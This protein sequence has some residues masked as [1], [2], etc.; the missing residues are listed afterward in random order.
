MTSDAERMALVEAYLS[1]AVEGHGRAAAWLALDQIDRGSRCEDVIVDLL[2]A[3]QHEVGERWLANEWTVADE[4][5]ASGSTQ[6]AL[7]AV[8]STVDV[9]EPAGSVLV[10]CAEGDWHSL[11][12]QM[13]AEM[14]RA[15]GYDVAFLGASTPAEHV[16]D[17]VRRR[18]PDAVAI[19]CNLPLFFPGV[20]RLA[21]A[22][23]T[24]G[25]P[26]LAGGRAMG[27]DESRA[28]LLGADAWV[29]GL[30]SA[31]EMLHRWQQEPPAVRPEPTRLDA[32]AGLLDVDANDVADQAFDQLIRA[33]PRMS[34]YDDAQLART[35]EDLAFITRFA[36]AALLV[37]DPTVLGEFLGW[38][39]ELLAN[40]GVPARALEAGLD[41][42]TPLLAARDSRAGRL[43]VEIRST[44]A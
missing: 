4:H 33:F 20:A 15:R 17:L 6:H 22:A 10:V 31:V 44:T 41:V 2:A 21:D 16:L 23:H 5:L 27:T 30:D 43:L 9:P 34:S 28:R 13:L 42:L 18:R 35:R 3:S 1:E 7:D 14:L 37:A 29:P 24:H 36:A 12:S 11:P 32:S 26:V 39:G 40:R 25:I 8:A 19:S 38:L